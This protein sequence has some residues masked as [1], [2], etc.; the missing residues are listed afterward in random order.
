[1]KPSSKKKNIIIAIILIFI[2]FLFLI[3]K[4]FSNSS[5]N[6]NYFDKII[7]ITDSKNESLQKDIYV[8][9]VLTPNF[10]NILHKYSDTESTVNGTD[11]NTIHS[12]GNIYDSILKKF[13][14]LKNI[15]ILEIGV[16]SGS[17]LNV[18]NEYLPS[19]NLYGF[20]ITLDN[21]KIKKNDKIK[22]FKGDCSKSDTLNLLP[23][24][25][26]FDL[27]I[28]DG[29]HDPH[30]QIK[31]F[32]IFNKKLK[33]EGM[34]IIEDI[35]KSNKNHVLQ[36]VNNICN[37]KKL[38]L[39]YFDLRYIKNRFDDIIAVI[40]KKTNILVSVFAIYARNDNYKNILKFINDHCDM[41][42]IIYSKNKDYDFDIGYLKNLK[43]YILIE[44]ENIGYDL[45]KYYIG[46]EYIISN[47]IKYSNIL[48]INDSFTFSRNIDDFFSFIKK[49]NA[50]FIGINN[51]LQLKNHFHSF[52]WVF[53][54]YIVSEF[55]KYFIKNFKNNMNQKNIVDV[56][57]IGF[58]SYIMNKLEY[59]SK[60]FYNVNFNG[61]PTSYPLLDKMIN[62][63]DY[64]IRKTKI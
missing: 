56:F 1:M 16:Y 64:P 35:N 29:S 5:K 50:D 33:N 6:E 32:E 39:R 62:E 54:E 63:Y 26:Y 59:I 51:S 37:E 52:I 40:S 27:I 48:L 43:N 4:I 38:N 31:T 42:I 28:E 20:D 34:Y 3:F 55:I 21:I 30:E 23:S 53:D 17:F 44:V 7:S 22:L 13:I 2:F 36:S 12:Y 24:D 14:G 49:T 41:I 47:N 45:F 19:A 18:L 15:N 60:S 46:L 11:K 57:E 25:L 10:E 61:N 9:T 58:S 8:K